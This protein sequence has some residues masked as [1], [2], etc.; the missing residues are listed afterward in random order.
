MSL[1]H[2][3]TNKTRTLRARVGSAAWSSRL[4]TKWLNC[5]L[6]LGTFWMVGVPAWPQEPPVD[7]ANQSIEDLMNIRATSV[8]K[9]EQTLSRTAAAIF[10]ITAE[11]IRHSGATN[12]P[13]LL[14]MAPGVEVAQITANSWAITARGLNQEFASS[15]LV[16]VDGRDL[17]A[18][19]PGGVFWDVLDP[20]LEAIERIEVIRGPGARCG[21]RTR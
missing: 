14:R 20:P 5:G 21:E 15:L 16:L 8:S 3:E 10:V 4:R 13:D 7:L 6:L 11:D 12:I 18:P 17:Y 1:E 2:L 19:T 9:K